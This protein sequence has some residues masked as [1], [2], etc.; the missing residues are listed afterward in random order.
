MPLFHDEVRAASSVPLPVSA[1]LD[2]PYAY[3][4]GERFMHSMPSYL[5]NTVGNRLPVLLNR[6]VAPSR[7]KST[8][9]WRWMAP[10]T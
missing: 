1:M 6:S 3:T 5:V 10:V 9:L 2:W 7:W 8:L 4:I